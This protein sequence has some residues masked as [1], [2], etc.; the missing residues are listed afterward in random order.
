MKIFG[1]LGWFKDLLEVLYR[2]LQ[3]SIDEAK[4]KSRDEAKKK[5]EEEEERRK[6]Y[7]KKRSNE[8][9]KPRNRYWSNYDE[10]DVEEEKEEIKTVT[11]VRMAMAKSAV[12]RY[13]N[14]LEYRFLHDRVSEVFVE[15]LT[16]VPNIV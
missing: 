7:G 5:E 4:K 12:D 16:S 8:W 10:S 3:K 13:Q 1:E 6:E 14:D 15:M 11:D 2:V 9:Q